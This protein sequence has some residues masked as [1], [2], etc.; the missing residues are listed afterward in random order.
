MLQQVTMSGTW[1]FVWI[2]QFQ[3]RRG[4]FT[5]DER[6]VKLMTSRIDPHKKLLK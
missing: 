3:S 1:G 6:S 5:D 2:K 4:R